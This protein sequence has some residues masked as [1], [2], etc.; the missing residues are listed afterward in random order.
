MRSRAAH[1]H[2]T[3]F[4]RPLA[5]RQVARLCASANLWLKLFRRRFSKEYEEVWLRLPLL[6]SFGA[7]IYVEVIVL[8]VPLDETRRSN[9]FAGKSRTQCSGSFELLSHQPISENASCAR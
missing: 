3:C 4:D 9:C 8:S 5:V 2:D 1:L 6:T 7:F